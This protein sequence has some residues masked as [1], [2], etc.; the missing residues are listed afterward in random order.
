MQ[1]ALEGPL[2]IIA[3][4][5]SFALAVLWAR[6]HEAAGWPAW[7][8]TPA[9]F[10]ARALPPGTQVLVLSASGRHHDILRAARHA[11]RP[12]AVVCDRSAPLCD[13]VRSRGG[14]ALILPPVA[15]TGLGDHRPSIGFLSLLARWHG[16]SASALFE[17]TPPDVSVDRPAHVLTLGA[18]LAAPAAI[19]FANRCR[20]TGLATAR[21]TDLRD[22]AHGDLL[23]VPLATTCLVLF[24][25]TAQDAYQAEYL[26]VL[27][28]DLDRIEITTPHAGALAGID[29]LLQAGRLSA[30]W[31]QRFD[32]RP[33]IASLPDWL[34]ALYRLAQTD[35]G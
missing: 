8:L 33:S 28:P 12:Y 22:V 35:P 31:Q 4:G 34:K 21:A 25:P 19:D 32:T 30:A 13:L 14:D 15:A 11:E 17:R 6:L 5:G 24:A 20:E 3:T 29:L 9:D 7:A 26:R 2:A 18:G 1:A 10:C 16:V 23:A 27:P